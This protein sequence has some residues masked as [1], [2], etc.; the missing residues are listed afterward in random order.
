MLPREGRALQVAV[1]DQ[2]LLALVRALEKWR[3]LLITADVT[4]YTDHRG[5]Q[6]L[7][8]LRANK[9]IKPRVARWLEF[10]ADFQNL[11]IVYKPGMSN[12]VAD[13]LSRNPFYVP[14]ADTDSRWKEMIAQQLQLMS[15][16]HVRRIAEGELSFQEASKYYKHPV[17]VVSAELEPRGHIRLGDKY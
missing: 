9:Q 10:L 3:R 8:D 15:V 1:Y 2:E 7:L 16:Q 11:R 6:Y 17:P 13:A 5:L 12:V 14:E 4:A